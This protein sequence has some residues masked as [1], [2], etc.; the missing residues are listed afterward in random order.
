MC[1]RTCKLF[2]KFSG[3]EELLMRCELTGRD[4]K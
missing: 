1:A 2:D 4:G 3:Y